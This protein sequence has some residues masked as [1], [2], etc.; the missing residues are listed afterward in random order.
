MKLSINNSYF[1]KKE[2]GARR[3]IEET[4]ELIKTLGFDAVDIGFCSPDPFEN[5]IYRENSLKEAERIRKFADDIGLSIDQ[6]HARFDYKRGTH[7]Q[8]IKDNNDTVDVSEILGVKTIV[9]HGDTYFEKRGIQDTNE[10]LTKVY[11]TFAPMVERTA[12]SDIKVAF[13][14]LFDDGRAPHHLHCRFCSRFDELMLLVD[15]F[16]TDKV[17]VCWDFGHARCGIGEE[18][19]LDYLEKVGDKLIATHVHD[20][21]CHE[22]THSFPYMGGTDWTRALE[23]L[24]KIGYRGSFTFEL[25]YGAFPEELLMD[26]GKLFVKTGRYMIS[27]IEG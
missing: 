5:I 1:F 12:G 19:A 23:I 27:K 20:N 9:V 16:G 26:F 18:F 10:V 6:A 11:D 17:G 24:K 3:S 7:E 15:K 13:E 25:V 2:D 4:F 22:D 8:F 14:N 21:V